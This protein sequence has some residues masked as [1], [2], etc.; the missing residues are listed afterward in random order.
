MAVRHWIAGIRQIDPK[1][2]PAI[3]EVTGIDRT[4]ILW[5]PTQPDQEEAA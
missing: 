3:E 1:Y 2:C 4:E 5:G